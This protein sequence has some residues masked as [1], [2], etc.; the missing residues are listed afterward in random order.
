MEEEKTDVN[1]FVRPFDTQREKKQHFLRKQEQ[2]SAQKP[3]ERDKKA[4]V[5]V[6]RPAMAGGAG[7]VNARREG[8]SDQSLDPRVP[9]VM[10]DLIC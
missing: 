9:R 7:G 1:R 3:M 2:Q 5:Q 4:A 6:E 8:L 10:A